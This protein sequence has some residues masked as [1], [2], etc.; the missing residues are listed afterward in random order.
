VTQIITTNRTPVSNTPLSSS[1][2]SNRTI[3]GIINVV[4]SISNI[5]IWQGVISSKILT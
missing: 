3:A 1:A 2:R 5:T 4:V